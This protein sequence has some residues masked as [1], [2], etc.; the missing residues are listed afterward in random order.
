MPATMVVRAFHLGALTMK[1]ETNFAAASTANRLRSL[2]ADELVA[3]NGGLLTGGEVPVYPSAPQG[4]GTM[5]M[6]DNWKAA[7]TNE[8][9]SN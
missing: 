3:V 8:R 1:I 5:G 2:T 4:G 6:K 9:W 7:A